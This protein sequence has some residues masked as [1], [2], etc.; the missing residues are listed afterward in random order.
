MKD[1]TETDG[2]K[3]AKLKSI[4]F[5]KA[6]KSKRIIAY[7][8]SPAI[9]NNCDSPLPYDKRKNKF[10]GHSCAASFNNVGVRRHS[11]SN[12]NSNSN[13]CEDAS[14]N[15]PYIRK[16]RICLQ[17]GVLFHSKFINSKYCSRTCSH[18]HKHKLNINKWLDDQTALRTLYSG[19]RRYL[20]KQADYKCCQCGWGVKNPHSNTYPLVVDH[21]NGNSEDNRLENLRVLCPN[22]DSLTSTYKALNKGNG[23][24]SRMKRYN[25]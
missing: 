17:C 5:S 15:E 6:Q 22:C 18:E 1:C 23:R 9:C 3:K 4:E 10:C 11:N 24:H 16:D 7:D 8:E 19:H 13:S 20:L 14:S 12:S 21:I 2:W 25:E